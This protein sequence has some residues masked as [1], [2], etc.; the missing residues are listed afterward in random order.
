VIGRATLKAKVVAIATVIV[1]IVVVL[2]IVR[3]RHPERQGVSANPFAR[4]PRPIDR[5]PGW[6]LRRRV[7]ASRRIGVYEQ[8]GHRAALYLVRVDDEP[9]LCLML[10]SVGAAGGACSPRLLSGEL[11]IMGLSYGNHYASGRVRSDVRSVVVVGTRGRRHRIPVH[12]GGGFIYRCPAFSGCTSSIYSIEAYGADG[13]RL[14]SDAI[15]P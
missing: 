7:L 6:L 8:E 12:T 9:G 4:E 10:V 3:D 5:L 14:G 1:A 13:R 15:P 11:A 2:L